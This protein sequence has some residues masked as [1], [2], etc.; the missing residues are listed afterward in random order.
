M[1]LIITENFLKK[2][3]IYYGRINWS[4]S[5]GTITDNFCLW[6]IQNTCILKERNSD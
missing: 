6:L 3:N 4:I 5:I 2:I 1:H